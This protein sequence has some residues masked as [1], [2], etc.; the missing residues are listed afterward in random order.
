MTP[1]DFRDINEAGVLTWECPT[2]GAM[3]HDITDTCPIC[4]PDPEPVVD[5]VINPDGSYKPGVFTGISRNEIRRHAVVISVIGHAVYHALE[6]ESDDID[7]MDEIVESL[8]R[9]YDSSNDAYQQAKDYEDQGFGMSYKEVDALNDFEFR[10]SDIYLAAEKAW[11]ID[12]PVE[13]RFKAGDQVR[14]QDYRRGSVTGVVTSVRPE[15]AK[16]RVNSP[17]LGHSK[18]GR[19]GITGVVVNQEDAELVK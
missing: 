12:N 8:G 10:V 15:T 5:C 11:V 13:T 9:L 7:D 6:I 2:C 19:Q 16:I 18:P 14:F 3:I 4:I 1:E 17:D